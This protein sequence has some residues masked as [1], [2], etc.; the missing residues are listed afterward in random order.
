MDECTQCGREF[1]FDDGGGIKVSEQVSPGVV[2]SWYY[3][4]ICRETKVVQVM[5]PVD[6][7]KVVDF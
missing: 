3:C 5:V 2:D 7:S 4:H 1:N 6:E